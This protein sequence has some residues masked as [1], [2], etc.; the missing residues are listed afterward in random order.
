MECKLKRKWQVIDC[1]YL[2]CV[3]AYLLLGTVCRSKS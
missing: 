2:A 1:D 3:P